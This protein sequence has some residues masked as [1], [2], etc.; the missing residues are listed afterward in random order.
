M[1]NPSIVFSIKY[2]KYDDTSDANNFYRCKNSRNIIN[3]LSRENSGNDYSEKELDLI[4][5]LVELTNETE[6]N[7]L[8]YLK[9]RK[10]SSGLFSKS[11]LDDVKTVKQKLSKT[12]ATIYSSVTSFSAD[13]GNKFLTTPEEGRQIIADHLPVLL[14][15]TEFDFENIDWCG[16]VHTNTAHHHIHLLF[17]EKSPQTIDSSGNLC[18]S[19]KNTLPKENITLY[20]SSIVKSLKSYAMDYLSLRDEIRDGALNTIKSNSALFNQLESNCA[21]I[22]E[23]GNFQYGRLTRD[24]QRRVDKHIKQVINNDK[25]LE[26]KYSDYKKNLYNSQLDYISLVRENGAKTI[27]TS[28][29]GFY[30][31][32]VRELHTRCANAFLKMLKEYTIANNFFASKYNIK[33]KQSRAYMS[34]G[35]YRSE[36]STAKKM[37]ARDSEPVY[38][39]LL[40][41]FIKTTSVGIETDT[42]LIKNINSSIKTGSAPTNLDPRAIQLIKNIINIAANADVELNKKTIEQYKFEKERK[43]E[44]VIYEYENE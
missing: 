1:N 34:A 29:S 42:T 24:Q 4:N 10:G 28:I 23:K 16:A 14:K 32:R 12:Q 39:K 30:S 27:P 8:N 15:D 13:Y 35:G 22:I 31:D 19:K 41:D 20:K 3:Y 33:E 6:K 25:N 9:D 5:N 38:G 17:W 44:T 18:Y 40:A 43:G 36:Y 21:D 11:G 26:V 2:F 37:M 7:I